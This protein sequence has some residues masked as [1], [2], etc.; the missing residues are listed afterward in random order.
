[1][2]GSF[3]SKIFSFD[4]VFIGVFFFRFIFIN[5]KNVNIFLVVIIRY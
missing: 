4:V 1:M 5:R 2:G 3:E